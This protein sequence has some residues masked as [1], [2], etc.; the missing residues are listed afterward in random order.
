MNLKK[1]LFTKVLIL[2]LIISGSCGSSNK[3]F[4]PEKYGFI[5]FQE[6]CKEDL[7]NKLGKPYCTVLYND[8]EIICYYD[9]DVNLLSGDRHIIFAFKFKNNKLVQKKF[10]EDRSHILNDLLLVNENK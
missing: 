10:L 4:T 9:H 7:I 6:T 3:T 1:N 2:I 5:N 8:A